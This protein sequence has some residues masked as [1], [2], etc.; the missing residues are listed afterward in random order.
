MNYSILISVYYRDNP[1][2]FN[3]TLKSISKQ[4]YF[5][6]EVVLVIDG[7]I[8]RAIESVVSKYKTLLPLNIIRNQKNMGLPYCL[9]KGLTLSSN[10]LVGR[11]DAD[12]IIF[13]DR[14]EKQVNYLVE[15]EKVVVLG[16]SVYVIDKF[17]KV[18]N[19][20]KY[21]LKCKDIKKNMW[22]NSIAHGSVIYRK[23]KI[24]E[25]GSYNENLLRCEDYDLWFRVLKK[26][27]IIEN[28]DIFS[29]YWRFEPNDLFK[30][31]FKQKLQQ[32]LVG[33]NGSRSLKLPL[34]K[35]I[36]C[37]SPLV[38]YLLP[39]FFSGFYNKLKKVFLK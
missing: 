36:L 13:P 26:G 14:F 11:V 17:D 12:D 28:L 8:P 6:D 7:E 31:S 24:F 38:P 19:E 35:Q 15:N 39:R 30:S 5:P 18:I 16:A 20:R 27:L 32:V 22:R 33:F 10:E 29:G 1:D 23:S 37:F 34:W 21:P 3:K 4:T 2:W 25:V 9:N